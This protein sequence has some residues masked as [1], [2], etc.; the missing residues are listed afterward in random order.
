MF[1]L[2]ATSGSVFIAYPS[3]GIVDGLT[4]PILSS[5]GVGDWENIS[6]IFLPAELMMMILALIIPRMGK[7]HSKSIP[8]T[9]IGTII[10]S[11]VFLSAHS[12]VYGLNFQA[13]IVVFFFAVMT[14]I[15]YFATKSIVIPSAMHIGNN[16]WGNY[17]NARVFGM[18]AEA[19]TG[20]GTIL[21]SIIPMIALAIIVI[22]IYIYSGRKK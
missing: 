19:L 6:L 18:S 21:N 11:L 20:T 5:F 9:I 2:I 8:E 17:F 12:H 22:S 14:M 7:E 15:I 13:Q 4:D 1:A 16:F 3:F 10:G